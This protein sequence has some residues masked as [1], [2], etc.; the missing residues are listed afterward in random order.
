MEKQSGP[1]PIT[2]FIMLDSF[3]D[4]WKLFSE[5]L[6]TQLTTFGIIE[7]EGKKV[8][9]EI[10]VKKANIATLNFDDA[11]I[12][13]LTNMPQAGALGYMRSYRFM[14]N[15]IEEGNW[16]LIGFIKG[17]NNIP[18]TIVHYAALEKTVYSQKLIGEED[19]SFAGFSLN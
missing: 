14:R 1:L 9:V 15:I 3:P 5:Q 11:L 6:T 19:T 16:V 8:K 4:Q 13:L 2:G 10:E 12:G 17:K 18:V 7:Y